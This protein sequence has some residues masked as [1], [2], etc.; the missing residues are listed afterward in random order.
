MKGVSQRGDYAH[1]PSQS[2]GD[3]RHTFIGKRTGLV[4]TAGRGRTIPQNHG[5]LQAGQRQQSSNRPP[6]FDEDCVATQS[7]GL[8]RN[9]D[10]FTKGTTCWRLGSE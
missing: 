4:G 10:A 7:A 8:F 6:P 2:R 3:R 5:V 1:A 9:R